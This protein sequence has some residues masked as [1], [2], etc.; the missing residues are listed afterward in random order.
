MTLKTGVMAYGNSAILE[1]NY[2]LKYTQIEKSHLNC[3]YITE[4][5]YFYNILY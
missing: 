1:I 5:Y 4:Y 3:N 2:I